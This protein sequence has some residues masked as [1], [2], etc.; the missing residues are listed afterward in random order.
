MDYKQILFYAL[1]FIL[2]I[3]IGK[4]IKVDVKSKGGCPVARRKL[5]QL[6]RQL[7]SSE[8]SETYL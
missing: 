5:E 2:G 7:Q 8:T 6:K 3:I 4:V 1:T